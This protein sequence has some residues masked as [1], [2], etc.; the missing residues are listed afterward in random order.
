M[1]MTTTPKNPT[2]PEHVLLGELTVKTRKGTRRL[3]K[4]ECTALIQMLAVKAVPE[5]FDV[6]ALAPRGSFLE[7]IARHFEATDI[8]YALPVMHVVMTAASHLTQNGASLLVPGVGEVLPTLWMIG[9]APSGSSKT[10]APEEVDRIIFRGTSPEVERL[11]TGCTDAQWIVELHQSNGSFWFQDE[12]GKAFKSILTEANYRRIKPWCLDAYSH[13][14]IANR[15]KSEKTKLVIDRPYFTFHGLSVDDTWRDD[16]DLGSMLD[17]FCQRFGYYVAVPRSDTDIFDHFLYFEGEEVERRRET[18][19]GIWDS[20][21]AQEGASA[22]YT[23]NDEVL[24]F[25]K[26]WWASLRRTWGQSALPKSFIRRIGFAT[27]RYLM[28]LH[29]LLGKSRRPIDVETANLATQFAEYHFLS[30]LHVV[31]QYDRAKTSRI[32]VVADA[33]T[34]V[35]D[36]GKAVTSREVT[37]ALSKQQRAQFEKGE[38]AEILSVLN[39]IEAMPGLFDATSDARQKSSAIQGR[40]DEIQARL[41][42]NERKRNERRLRELGRGQSDIAASRLDRETDDELEGN[43]VQFHLPMTGTD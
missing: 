17:G 40:R 5:E 10:L 33:G 30:A 32:Q 43:V 42:L 1:N 6:R 27:L 15:L 37:R 13:K 23:L 16:I 41:L 19:A 31:Q 8:S 4:S 35:S 26:A 39:Q 38:I 14:T 2:S 18:L 21:C 20:L 11:P 29:F 28:V 3:T 34:R 12:V 36:A 25:L 24:P 22:P 9:L 7:R